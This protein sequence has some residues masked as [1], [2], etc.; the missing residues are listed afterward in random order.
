MIVRRPLL[1]PHCRDLFDGCKPTVA[2][3]LFER[4]TIQRIDRSTTNELS[5]LQLE[6]FSLH[7]G[8]ARSLVPGSLGVTSQLTEYH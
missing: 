1:N 8:L 7:S 5:S 4:N 6:L 2:D 3:R